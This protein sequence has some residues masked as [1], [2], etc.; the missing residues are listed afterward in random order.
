MFVFN[1]YL[2]YICALF[3]IQD[4][5]MSNRAKA[6]LYRIYVATNKLISNF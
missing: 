5:Y 2:I 6:K 4:H 3:K 1:T